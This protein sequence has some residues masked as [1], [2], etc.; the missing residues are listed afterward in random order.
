MSLQYIDSSYSFFYQYGIRKCPKTPKKGTGSAIQLRII[1][2]S[3]AM[4]IIIDAVQH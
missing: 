4:I 2:A 3:Y 1:V